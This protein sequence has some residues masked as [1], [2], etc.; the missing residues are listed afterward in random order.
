MKLGAESMAR[1][2]K[3]ELHR[4]KALL[5]LLGVAFAAEQRQQEIDARRGYQGPATDEE[6]EALSL[7]RVA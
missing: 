6:R 4:S 7:G 5:V 2:V 1:R 3:G